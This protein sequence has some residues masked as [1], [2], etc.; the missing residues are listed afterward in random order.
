MKFLSLKTRINKNNKQIN[1]S[2]P[3]KLIS[4]KLCDD[5]IKNRRVRIKFK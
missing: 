4:K 2:I 3:K 1:I 5:I